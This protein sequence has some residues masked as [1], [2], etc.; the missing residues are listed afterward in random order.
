[1]DLGLRSRKYEDQVAVVAKDS[2]VRIFRVMVRVNGCHLDSTRC[3]TDGGQPSGLGTTCVLNR[4]GTSSSVAR[5]P[6]RGGCEQ[7]AGYIL[8]AS[9]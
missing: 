8:Q 6:V 5:R 9:S 1:M 3:L 4:L 2:H 7:V